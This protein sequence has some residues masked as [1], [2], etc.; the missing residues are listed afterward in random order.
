MLLKQCIVIYFIL[1]LEISNNTIETCSC[2]T[3]RHNP[4]SKRV[5]YLVKL[6]N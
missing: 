4:Y 5:K 2:K 3:Y 6:P 1:Y